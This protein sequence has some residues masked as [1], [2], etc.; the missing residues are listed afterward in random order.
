MRGGEREREVIVVL[1]LVL[2]AS[3]VVVVTVA[4]IVVIESFT[5]QLLYAMHCHQCIQV[6]TFESSKQP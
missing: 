2:V 6:L 5:K 1:L 3:M 4:I